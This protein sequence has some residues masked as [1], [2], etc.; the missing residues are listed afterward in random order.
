[1]TT[2]SLKEGAWIRTSSPEETARCGAELGRALKAGDTVVLK[3]DIGSGKTTFT[4]GVARGLGFKAAADD[5]S[6]PTFVLIKEYPCRIPLYHIDLYRL[7]AITPN[8]R[9]L[10]EEA[11]DGT[12]VVVLEWGE[13]A[14]AFLPPSCLEIEFRHVSPNARE[15]RMKRA[16]R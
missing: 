7:D 2:T 6:S 12:G 3:G 9:S 11:M 10:I 15:I 1:M 13:K 5:V 4:K 8:E 14:R 16:V